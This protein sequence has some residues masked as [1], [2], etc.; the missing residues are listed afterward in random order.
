MA[1]RQLA[2]IPSSLP[3][4][5]MAML[6]VLVSACAVGPD[7]VRPSVPAP[8]ALTRT[9]LATAGAGGPVAPQWWKAFGSNELNNLVEQALA[10]SPTLSA[11]EAT[12]AAARENVIAQRGFFFPAVQAGYNATRQNVG[13][14]VSSPLNN[15]ASIYNY[16]T[17]QLNIA[18][19]PDLFGNNRRQVEGLQAMAEEQRFQLEAARLTLIANLVGAVL[20]ASVL[21]AQVALT[22]QAL[23]A[24]QEQL[25]YM[26]KLQRNGYSS[27]IDVATQEN[28]LTQAQQTLAP[29]QKQLEQTRDLVNVLG[30][31]T[32]DTVL[33]LIPLTA[34]KLPSLPTAVASDLVEQRPD[35]RAAETQVHAASA[36]IGV[37]QAARLPQFSITAALGAGATTLGNLFA[38][39]NTTWVI[40]AGLLQPVFMGG[41]LAA[42]ERAAD[43]QYR[44]TVAQYRGVVLSAFQN[45]ADSLYAL[46]IDSQSLRTAQASEAA[47]HTSFILTQSQLRQGYASHPAALATQQAWLQASA[48]RVAAQG[49]LLGDTVA[50]FQALGGGADSD[51]S[52]SDSGRSHQSALP[53]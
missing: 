4:S 1:A 10:R 20:Q 50:L 47:N 13:D 43:A 21:D 33:P 41:M 46:E 3:R 51:L 5:L 31:R 11:A 16:H 18:Y 52:G 17:A 32:P 38:A 27:G 49:A 7:Y 39:G 24:A 8:A 2:R 25:R 35:V 14:T 23:A 19:A 30:G 53:H 36:A 37:A 44:A 6:G 48:A 9:P 45:V 29:L 12:L 26:R 40:G 34:L 42:R 22:E 28:L 15:G